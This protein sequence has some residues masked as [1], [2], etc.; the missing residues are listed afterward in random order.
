VIRIN[1][2]AVSEQRRETI[3]IDEMIH[4]L[5]LAT[6]DHLEPGVAGV[7]AEV[8]SGDCLTEADLEL[9][10]SYVDGDRF[11]PDTC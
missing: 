10:C 11:V 7:M 4:A 9:V 1:R 6:G 3:A 8:D 5:T 2:D